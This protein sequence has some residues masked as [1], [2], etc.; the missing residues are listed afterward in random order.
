[1]AW[2]RP[3][4]SPAWRAAS[5]EGRRPGSR[6]RPQ[7][8][9]RLAALLREGGRAARPRPAASP[10]W[11]RSARPAGSAARA[12]VE[13]AGLGDAAADEHRVRGAAGRRG[14]RAP[15]PTTTVRSGHAQRFGVA[16]RCARRGPAAPRPRWRAGSGGAA[17]TRC[18]PSPTPAPISHSMAPGC[19]RRAARVTARISALVSWPSFSNRRRRGRAS[20]GQM[21]AR[22]R[23]TSIATVL[24]GSTAPRSKASAPASR[25]SARA[26]RPSPPAPSVARRRS[27]ARRAA[28]RRPPASTRPRTAPAAGA[29][30]EM[31][32]DPGQRAPVQR[33]EPAFGQRPAEP[34]A[35]EAEG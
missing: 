31:R 16:P 30:L 26:G 11:R 5:R 12:A 10:R 22:R 6:A 23:A 17:S 13:D 14:L 18:R 28:P 1:M 19:G 4:G 15:R 35:G 32:D 24:S 25:G 2:S 3:I 21:R 34:G 9:R 8:R 7:N 27:R 20:S 29:R 33:H